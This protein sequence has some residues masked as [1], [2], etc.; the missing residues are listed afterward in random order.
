MSHDF[1]AYSILIASL[2]R[3]FQEK[4]YIDYRYFHK[5]A[6]YLAYLAAGIQANNGLGLDLKFG[7]QNDNHLQPILLIDPNLGRS[8]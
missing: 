7:L 1:Q 6:C 3:I 5:K 2:Q 4:D 8:R